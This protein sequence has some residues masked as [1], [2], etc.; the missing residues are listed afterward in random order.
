MKTFTSCPRIK[1]SHTHFA[2]ARLSAPKNTWSIFININFVIR[3]FLRDITYFCFPPSL[4]HR[5]AFLFV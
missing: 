5:S 2:M 4:I 1:W 3:H